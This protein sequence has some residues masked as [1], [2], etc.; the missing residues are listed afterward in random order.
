M[1]RLGVA[2]IPPR[3][4]PM[5]EHVE[6]AQLAERYGYESLWAGE[7]NG[8]ELFTFLGALLSQTT[9]LKIAPGAASIF[10]HTPA[11][12]TMLTAILHL[13]HR[14]ASC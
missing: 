2:L 12:L 1:Q 4:I 11:L 13:M 8:L 14:S 7:S 9:R 6:I 3:D 5:A 10:T